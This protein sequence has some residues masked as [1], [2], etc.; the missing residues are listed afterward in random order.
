[1]ANQKTYHIGQTEYVD[2]VDMGILN[3]PAKIDTGA[4]CSAVWATNIKE[5]NNKLQFVLFGKQSSF[6]TG[7]EISTKNYSTSKIRNSFG[8]L[9]QRYKVQLKISIGDKIFKV[10]FSLANR[11]RNAYPTLLGQ[12]LL[13]GR[14]I[15]DVTK[16]N[17]H[18][19]N[20]HKKIGRI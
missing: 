17:V 5:E 7:K 14:F 11:S 3:V 10:D 2:F 8:S 13:K 9:R 1:M 12:K 18:S 4:T 20:N 19:D 6:Y 16:K 15:V